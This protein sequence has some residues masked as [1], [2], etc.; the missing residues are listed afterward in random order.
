MP[1]KDRFPRGRVQRSST[2]RGLRARAEPP[3]VEHES[4][5][6]AATRA[7]G[8]V[9]GVGAGFIA[10]CGRTFCAT[11]VGNVAGVGAVSPPGAS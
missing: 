4:D 5:G 10:F 2:V 1:I 3:A 7:A 8:L 6:A 9:G 11:A